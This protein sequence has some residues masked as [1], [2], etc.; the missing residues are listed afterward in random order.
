MNLSDLAK[1]FSNEDDAREF[2]E[3]FRWPDGPICPHCGVIGE[4]S[5]LEP[6]PGAK[7]HVRK[8][9]WKCKACRKQFSVTVGTI[10]SDSHI[11]LNKWLMALHLVCA[12]KKGMSAHQLHRMLGIGYRAA[13]FMAHRIRYAMT[14]GFEVGSKMS[15]PENTVEA[16]ETYVGGKQKGSRGKPTV[17][18]SN[19]TPVVALVERKGK[20][21]S[22]RVERVTINNLK[23]M[24]TQYVS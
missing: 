14:E 2:L 3:K 13:W 5:K 6:R 21:H 8:G 1:N 16:D 23:P 24:L 12:S 15:G 18:N 4:A 17:Y 19:K 22:F 7:T 11:P 20:V 10:F 9:V